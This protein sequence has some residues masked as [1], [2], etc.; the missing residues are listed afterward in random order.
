MTHQGDDFSRIDNNWNLPSSAKHEL[1]QEIFE[2]IENEEPT[3][4]FDSPMSMQD[5][6]Y[7][8]RD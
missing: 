6:L 4:N 1:N 2:P 7:I 5:H 3:I 8:D